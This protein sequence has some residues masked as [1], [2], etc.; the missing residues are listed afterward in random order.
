MSLFEDVIFVYGR[1]G[2]GAIMA[3]IQPSYCLNNSGT[4]SHAIHVSD[5]LNNIE[6]TRNSLI[7]FVKVDLS[8]NYLKYLKSKNNILVYHLGD[9]SKSDID[10]ALGNTNYDILLSHG[11][12]H[13]PRVKIIKHTYDLFLD[14]VDKRKFNKDRFSIL[15]CGNHSTCG[16]KVQGEFGLDASG[17]T[18]E[19]KLFQ[20]LGLYLNEFKRIN[21][22]YDIN[23]KVKNLIENDNELI[24]DHINKDHNITNYSLH[25]CVRTPHLSKFNFYVKSSTKL[26]QAIGCGSN[27]IVSLGP[28]ERAI[29]DSSY[30][31]SIDTETDEFKDKGDEICKEMLIKAKKEYGK[32]PWNDSLK[33]L[34]QFKEELHP[35]S[36][37]KKIVKYASEL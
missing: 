34:S 24:Y 13:N 15:W 32:K 20:P 21:N 26:S 1:H 14:K 35:L 2:G 9:R 29:I 36:F 25:Y 8:E 22:S 28:P 17:L 19:K 27:I 18:Y 5:F 30:R 10:S 3:C 7:V 37:A 16:Q 6:K 12:H 31:Y 33:Y 11:S 23:E 4:N